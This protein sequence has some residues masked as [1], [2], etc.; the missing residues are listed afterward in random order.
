MTGGG[1]PAP[2]PEATSGPATAPR[3]PRLLVLASTYPSGDHDGAP[4]F[5]RTLARRQ[6][7]RFDT[8]VL[9]P[10]VPG[11]AA[12]EDRDG[13]RVR[14]FRYFP[15][16]WEDLADGAILENLRA[17]RS[18]LLQVPAFLAAEA[19]AVRRAIREFDPDV[20]HVHWIVPQGLVALAAAR[21]RPWLVTTHG[22]DLYALGGPA[23]RLVKR[24]VLR[25]A[26]AATGVNAD[27]V[28]RMVELGA[29]AGRTA[30]L[31]MGAEVELVRARAATATR[32]PG[33]I[34]FVGRLVEKKGVAVLLAAL[35]L[36]AAR[37]PEL[38]WS[39]SV[40]GDGPLRA[41]LERDAAPLGGRVVF[42][43]QRSAERV[44][45][46]LGEAELYALPSLPAASG[47]QD[48]LPVA[49]IEGMAAGLAVVASRIPGVDEAVR[50]GREGLLVPP[51]DAE[52][53]ADA[54]AGLL[55]D[56]ARRAELGR[57]ASARADEY[58]ADVI[59]ARYADLLAEVARPATR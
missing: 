7:E 27:M 26:S 41:E 56:P 45:T 46:L 36:L 19:L 40:A 54:L 34:A 25:R 24:A 22:G 43:G 18:R 5:V 1:R 29:P 21:G 58:S 42:H 16:R 11:A 3:R 6:A 30:A 28:R 32:T 23:W 20:V 53:L 14:R 44:A 13:L 33:R 48:G 39:L 2:A 10:N 59:G 9:V 12:T 55:A 52:A 35:R 47:D 17:R 8:L 15:A 51:G 50:S 57:A 31:P 4:A 49:L 37:Q 38:D